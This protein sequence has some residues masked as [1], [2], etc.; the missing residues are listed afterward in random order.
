MKKNKF[1]AILLVS[2]TLLIITSCASLT[3]KGKTVKYA[4]KSEAPKGCKLI[5]EVE[6]WG[7]GSVSQLKIKMR[8]ET[9]EKGGNYLVVDTIEKERNRAYIG[10]GR[11]YKCPE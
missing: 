2:S 8:N 6:P 9:G 11:A 1:L 4:T 7:A 10:T 5:G 3:E